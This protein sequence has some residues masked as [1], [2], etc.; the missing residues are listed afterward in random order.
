MNIEISFYIVGVVE[1]DLVSMWGIETDL[2]AASGSE[3]IWSL[4]GGRN[5]LGFWA[6]I[7]VNFVFVCRRQLNDQCHARAIVIT[8]RGTR[9]RRY[10]VCRANRE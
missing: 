3:C 5:L 8:D 9:N 2:I 6:W 10:V 1:V 7:N 4:C